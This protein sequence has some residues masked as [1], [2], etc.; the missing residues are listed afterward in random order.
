MLA[1]RSVD[2]PKH[3]VHQYEEFPWLRNHLQHMSAHSRESE[4]QNDI[5]RMHTWQQCLVSTSEA[6]LTTKCGFN[7]RQNSP[8]NIENNQL[9]T[10]DRIG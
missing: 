2:R 1:C 5:A 3:V 8:L 4:R 7:L 6:I 9:T 10:R